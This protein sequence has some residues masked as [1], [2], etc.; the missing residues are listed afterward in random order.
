MKIH[1]IGYVVANPQR[2]LQNLAVDKIINELYDPTQEAQLML[3]DTN[4]TYIELITPT[5]E[6]SFTWN[7]LQKGGGYHHLC[8]EVDSHTQAK[9]II[10]NKKMIQTL[11]RVYAPL[12]DMYVMFAVDRNKMV[13]EF[14]WQE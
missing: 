6:S 12:L 8:Y 9:E 13:V 3:I 10:L 7:F 1:H 11:D 2:F 14:A 5:K 4:N